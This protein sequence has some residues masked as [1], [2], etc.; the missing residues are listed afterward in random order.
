M[1]HSEEFVGWPTLLAQLLEQR[2]LGSEQ[3]EAAITEI[4]NGVATPSQMTAFIV[5]LRAKGETS[6]EL[7]GMLRAVRAAGNRVSLPA[8][9]AARSMDIVGTGGDKSNS[10]NV[11][12]MSALVVAA[13]GVPV[14]KHGNRAASSKC[15][16]ADLLEI[17]GVAVELDPIG[18]QTCVEEV[19]FGFCLAARFHPAFRYTAPSRREIGVPTAFNLLG[20]MANP[21]PIANMLVGVA[22]PNMMDRM[23]E[24]LATRGIHSAWVV[25]GHGGLDELAVSGPNR[26]YELKEGAVRQFD[27]SA[28][29]YGITLSTL[30]DIRGGEA[31]D[32]LAI[33]EKTFAG[34][35]GA[36]R[37]IVVFNAG[38]ALHI[39]GVASG[40]ADGIERAKQLIDS[41]AAS[42]KL[43]Q[44]VTV[45][46]REKARME[47]QP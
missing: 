15:G 45:S 3:A 10:V 1:A 43:A 32:N 17:A 6:Q 13:A 11:S 2:D 31:S 22:L 41:G 24:A 34:A 19:G 14:C 39:A 44:V 33:L 46:Q 7:E 5:A 47:A 35:A 20:P 42:A 16:S 9:I 27:V 8:D 21:A 36:V 23:A 25:H 4:L 38:C 37:D 26:V 30:E 28:S 12:T 29:D 18:V 40:V